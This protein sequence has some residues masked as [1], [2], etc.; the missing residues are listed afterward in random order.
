MIAIKQKTINFIKGYL[1]NPC[2]SLLNSEIVTANL[3]DLMINQSK[4][5]AL[6]HVYQSCTKC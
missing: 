1:F 3:N 6:A 4:D 2:Q 5:V